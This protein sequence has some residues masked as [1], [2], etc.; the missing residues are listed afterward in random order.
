M[1]RFGYQVETYRFG[2]RALGLYFVLAVVA[3]GYCGAAG[4]A[5]ASLE[6]ELTLA[7]CIALAVRNN[8]DLAAG[9]LDR[10]AQKLSLQDAED[11]FRPSPSFGMS[12]NHNSTGAELGGRSESSNIG[13]SPRVTLRMP[14]GGNFSL[15][16]PNTVQ[17]SED[18]DE[19]YRQNVEISFK[20]PLLRGGG[21]QVGTAGIVAARRAEQL[22]VLGFKSAVMGLVTQTILAYRNVI[23]S[24]RAVEIAKRSVQRARELLEVNRILIDTGRMAKQDIVQ[25]EANIAERELGLTEAEGSLNDARLAL[26]D[27]LDIDSRTWI[28]PTEPLRMEAARHNADRSVMLALKNRTDYL[29]ALLGIESAKTALAV[30]NN[31]RKWGLDL[32]LTASFGHRGR[33]LSEAYGRFD[34]TYGVGLSVDIP[35]G[36]NLG[37]RQRNYE[38]ARIALRRS[39][40]RLAELRQSIDVEVRAAVRDVEVQRRRAELAKRARE[41]TERKLEIERIKLHAGLTT[42]FRVVRFEDDLVRSQNNEIGAVIAYLNALTALDRTQGT[43]LDTWRIEIDSPVD[44]G[45]NK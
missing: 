8:R 41:L 36:A 22:G 2:K 42:N 33:S 32:D 13:V 27:I 23:R 1:F 40:L 28:R 43:T 44:E 16:A 34:D 29:S 30:A 12:L 4:P 18:G 31:A 6:R 21:T 20:Q 19:Q 25:T 24:K 15:S 14:T 45:E 5:S 3:L 38:K 26:I 10:L 7:E 37:A 35:L 9:R 39:H 17:I 11:E